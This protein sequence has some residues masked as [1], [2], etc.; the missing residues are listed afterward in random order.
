MRP[1]PTAS[2]SKVEIHSSLST[3]PSLLPSI[4]NSTDSLCLT[5]QNLSPQRFLSG[6]FRLPS[7]TS[8]GPMAALD[9]DPTIPRLADL[10]NRMMG[11]L[12]V[13]LRGFDAAEQA[14][15]DGDKQT[16]IWREELETCGEQQGGEYGREQL[17]DGQIQRKML[18]RISSVCS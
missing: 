8:S 3:F 16:M 5:Y 13:V 15:K 2:S 14:F 12:D 1:S 17:T 7:S 10:S 9:P 18:M 11:C 6:T 4:T